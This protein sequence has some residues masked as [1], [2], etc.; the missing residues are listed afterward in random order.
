V[1]VAAWPVTM[2]RA[3]DNT[4]VLDDPHVAPH[5][6]RLVPAG[7]GALAVRVGDSING[8]RLDRH[9]LKAGDSMPVPPGPNQLQLGQ[10]RLRLRRAGDAIA[11]EM[12][13]RAEARMSVT[14]VCLLLLLVVWA[15]Q[16]AIEMDPGSK[17]IDWA[18]LALGVPLGL[19]LWCV[20]WGIASKLFQHRFEFWSHAG[21]AS[22]GLL[23]AVLTGITLTLVASSLGSPALAHAQE[24]L[25]PL[26]IGW[27]IA[28]H[29][30]EA[31][32]LSRRVVYGAVATLTV[33][34]VAAGVVLNQHRNDRSFSELYMATLP[35][36]AMRLAGG[37][38]PQAFVAQAQKLRAPLDERVRVARDEDEAGDDDSGE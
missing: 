36:P 6:L 4:I 26:I 35:L 1:D 22:R 28:A 34:I 30:Q 10:T 2:G 37:V 25:V 29:A 23:V 14:L 15:A 38:E 18:G 12:P 17:F 11:A 16:H 5:H 31:L 32:P 13:L 27:M 19:G 33:G 3:L 9:R 7:D 8:L 20:G 21:I 24:I